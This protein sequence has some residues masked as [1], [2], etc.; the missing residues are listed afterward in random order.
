MLVKIR[1]IKFLVICLAINACSMMGSSNPSASVPPPPSNSNSPAAIILPQP[2]NPKNPVISESAA[3]I[4]NESQPTKFKQI[5]E[6]RAPGGEVSKV[7]IDNPG[8]VPD[9]YLTPAQQSDTNNNPD[10][11]STPSWQWSW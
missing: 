11:L 1:N 3:L 10:K 6:N 9:Y 7:T 8:K 4:A 5:K 2:G